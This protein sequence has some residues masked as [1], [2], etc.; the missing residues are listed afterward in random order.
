IAGVGLSTQFKATDP[1]FR[2]PESWQWNLTVSREIL[3]DTV[4]EA[5]YIGNHGLH[6]WRRGVSYNDVTPSSRLSIARAQRFDSDNVQALIDANRIYK[7]LG[8][9]DGTGPPGVSLASGFQFWATRRF[10]SRLSFQASYSWS[11]AISN[12][13]LQSYVN[14]TTDPFNYDLDR[15]DADLDRRQMFVANAVYVLPSFKG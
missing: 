15:G 6:I 8:P 12:I 4:V 3:K 7:G 2:P 9:I 10:S 5:S 1:N 14:G 11:H 13:P